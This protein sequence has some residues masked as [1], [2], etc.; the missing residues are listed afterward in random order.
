[1]PLYKD[2]KGNWYIKIKYTD[3]TGKKKQ[4]TKRGLKT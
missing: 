3:W 2:A 4:T 1:M